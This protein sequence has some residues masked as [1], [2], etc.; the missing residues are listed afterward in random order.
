MIK[1]NGDIDI[2]LTLANYTPIVGKFDSYKPTPVDY[3]PMGEAMQ[4]AENRR[5]KAADTAAAIDN[6]FA[7]I[8][9][10]LHQD[11]E[12]ASWFEGFKD[13]Y[14]AQVD[15]LMR[16]GDYGNAIYYGKQLASQ[17]L[18]DP[19]LVSRLKTNKQ[20]EAKKA[21]VDDMLAK[22]QINQSIAD[23]WNEENDYKYN[24]MFDNNGN[25]IGAKDYNSSWMPVKQADLTD[26]YKELQ[27][28]VTR[29]Q[30]HGEAVVFLGADG[31]ET[32]DPTK[33]IYGIARK[34][35]STYTHLDH[36]TLVDA[37]NELYEANPELKASLQQDYNNRVWQFGKANNE[38]KQSFYDSDIA[39]DQGVKYSFEEY[40]NKRVNPDLKYYQI[41]N[42]SNTIDYGA[43]YDNYR[44]AQQERQLAREFLDTSTSEGM[45]FEVDY[46]KDVSKTYDDALGAISYIEKMYNNPKYG[47][48]AKTSKWLK[49]PKYINAKNKGDYVAMANFLSKHLLDSPQI[50]SAIRTL[51][52]QG[53]VLNAI[54]GDLPKD[55][56]DIIIAN[57]AIQ[58]GFD[59]PNASGNKY[60][61]KIAKAKNKLFSYTS[62]GKTVTTN[63]F[64]L[65]FNNVNHALQV[66]KQ[67]G[68]S[69]G[70]LATYGLTLRNDQD[71]VSLEVD[72][73]SP[74][75][76]RIANIQQGNKLQIVH[77]NVDNGRIVEH[78]NPYRNEDIIK[79]IA[80]PQYVVPYNTNS[81]IANALMGRPVERKT[82]S[83]NSL[84]SIFSDN[85]IR[86]ELADKA[87]KIM[88]KKKIG[89]I[90][91]QT[92]PFTDFNVNNTYRMVG[93]GD[94]KLSDAK[95]MATILD[96]SNKDVA[97]QAIANTSNTLEI[98]QKDEE[99]GVMRLIKVKDESAIREAI[100]K[101]MVNNRFK[102]NG[103]LSPTS[104]G[105]GTAITLLP[106]EDSNNGKTKL[107]GAT[108]FIDGLLHNEA[109]K[110]ALNSRDNQ[111]LDKFRHYSSYG[112]QINDIYGN[113]I[114]YDAPD[115]L[116]SF[117]ASETMKTAFENIH[118]YAE[119]GVN[120]SNE[121][122]VQTAVDILDR[123]GINK[124]SVNRE[125]YATQLA[126]LIS[127]LRTHYNNSIK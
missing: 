46:S 33:G 67:L 82:R 73:R 40:V 127:K 111:Y 39:D 51:K 20:Y 98:W 14:K 16:A 19:E 109:A 102:M 34:T 79:L 101:A 44:K 29:R 86:K 54:I 18:K 50:K 58:A 25:V 53:E 61:Q 41:H 121:D 49:D 94:W 69:Q 11:A 99:S 81:E 124:N 96:E 100:I 114:N 112:V 126:I 97:M 32:S 106:T 91:T 38:T 72:K 84:L 92:S 105:F 62:D 115:A 89:L 57:A 21:T 45:I 116:Q 123:Q 103:A 7:A 5:Y 10:Q 35:G 90:S 31:K 87:K 42:V 122:F 59:I 43:G 93:T 74:L 65:I 13:K 28:V 23:Q 85:G 113:P 48:Y 47:H 63:S 71:G 24:P 66:I 95:S 117:S 37:F 56:K 30:G 9:P 118:D 83:D 80:Q 3:K 2:P 36:K 68:I 75:L 55:D 110:A 70:E 64:G 52:H 17:A 119:R 8:A 22:G 125:Y 76:N 120:I 60:A 104:S 78:I 77:Y 12:T 1:L 6:A 27:Q 107:K 15:M 108:F 88:N 26:F 4:I